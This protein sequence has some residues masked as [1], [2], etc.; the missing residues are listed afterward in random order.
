MD[1]K[2]KVFEVISPHTEQSIA[3]VAAAG[4]AEVEAAVAAARA[5]FDSGPL[6]WPG[7]IRRVKS[8]GETTV[9][10]GRQDDKPSWT[11]AQSGRLSHVEMSGSGCTRAEASA[12]APG[13]LA[14]V[15]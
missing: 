6:G 12:Q 8:T 5:A 1:H 11:T 3:Q 9:N 15:P 14:V 2:A 7:Q 10:E 4:P 13:R